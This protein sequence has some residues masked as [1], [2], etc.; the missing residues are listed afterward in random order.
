MYKNKVICLCPKVNHT[1]TRN[2]TF[3]MIKVVI[4]NN[5]YN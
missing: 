1:E 4:F 2:N 5:I 3:Q